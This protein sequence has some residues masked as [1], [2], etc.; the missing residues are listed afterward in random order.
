[1]SCDEFWQERLTKLKAT[2]VL[3]EDAID[4]LITGGVN[5]YTLDTGQSR[6]TVTKWDIEKLQTTLDSLLNRYSTLEARCSG[7]NSFN[8]TAGF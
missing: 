8:A 6:Q 2:I 3:Y 4:A 7:S 5:S 1:M